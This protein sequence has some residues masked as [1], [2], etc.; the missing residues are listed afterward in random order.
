MRP[1]AEPMTVVPGATRATKEDAITPKFD[2]KGRPV[3]DMPEPIRYDEYIQVV[4][5]V[6][7]ENGQKRLRKVKKP[8]KFPVYRGVSARLANEIRADQRRAQRKAEE[9][10]YE[11]GELA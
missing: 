7:T 1:F 2:S 4:T 6:V 5:Q 11:E 8:V 9:A 10:R 3:W